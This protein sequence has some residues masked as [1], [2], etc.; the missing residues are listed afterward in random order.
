[1]RAQTVATL[2]I[3]FSIMFVIA[4]ACEVFMDDLMRPSS[5]FGSL[6]FS[7]LFTGLLASLILEKMNARLLS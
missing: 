4:V 1:M 6:I 2:F 5:L 3:V 7:T